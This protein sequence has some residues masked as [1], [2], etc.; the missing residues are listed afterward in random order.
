MRALLG[1]GRKDESGDF[2]KGAGLR[3]VQISR[4]QTYL[5]LKFRRGSDAQSALAQERGERSP[6]FNPPGEDTFPSANMSFRY[7][8]DAVGGSA[9]G[10]EGIAELEEIEALSREVGYGPGRIIFNSSVVRGLEYYTG[11]VFEAELTFEVAG[12]DGRPVRFGSIGGGGRYDGLVGRFR[13]EDVPATGFS[14]G[15]S[16]FYAALKAVGSPIVGAKPQPGPV[17][18]LALDKDQLAHYQRFVADLRNAGVGPNSISVPP[19]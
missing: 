7:W 9:V 19:A 17:I 3:D 10:A 8:R 18:V 16:R 15:V 1:E 6:V 4:I 11:P 2:T 13:G 5:T 14:I 12:D